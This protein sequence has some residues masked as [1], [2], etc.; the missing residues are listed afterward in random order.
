MTRRRQSLELRG[1]E[2]AASSTS[3]AIPIDSTTATFRPRY[4]T[5]KFSIHPSVLCTS[6][7]NRPAPTEPTP[8]ILPQTNELETNELDTMCYDY[9]IVWAC[10]HTVRWDF[11]SCEMGN[12]PL[13]G[14]CPTGAVAT[15]RDPR[16]GNCPACIA[17]CGEREEARRRKN[18]EV[19]SSWTCEEKSH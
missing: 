19:S 6:S 15:H 12:R 9:V 5:F 10:G 2:T 4:S 3:T 8:P 13:A 14:G 1:Q 16:I 17:R 7:D 18:A 11:V